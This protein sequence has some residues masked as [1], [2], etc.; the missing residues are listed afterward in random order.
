M[1]PNLLGQRKDGDCV[2]RHGFVAGDLW[3]YDE[4]LDVYEY[5]FVDFRFEPGPIYQVPLI[6]RFIPQNK[7]LDVVVSRIER[8]INTMV[9]GFWMKKQGEQ[10]KPTN[11][12]GGIV[13]EY[14][15]T[16][17]T[18]GNIS[19]VPGFV[20]SFMDLLTNYIEEQGVTTTTL[21]KIPKGVRSNAAIE[22]L[23]ESE[24]ASLAIPQRRYKQTVKHI[25]EKFLMIADDYFVKPQQ[26]R[27]L[28]KGEPNYFDVIGKKAK[29]AREKLGVPVEGE[30]ISLSSESHVDIEVEAGLGFT[31]TGKREAML[32]LVSEIFLPLAEKGFI[33]KQAVQTIVE[34]VAETYQFGATAELMSAFDSDQPQFTE[35]QQ[36]NLE[37]T[38]QVAVATVMKDLQG[39]GMFPDEQQRID[40]T[41][42]GEAEAIKDT[43]L[44]DNQSKSPLDEA[45]LEDKMQEMRRKEEKHQLSLQKMRQGI[46]IADDKADNEIKIK[47]AEA[48][49]EMVLKEEET[50]AKIKVQE[51]EAE[52][53]WKENI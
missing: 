18:Q 30:V 5:P 24:Y 48:I 41:K 51:K 33:P 15:S 29:E 50:D 37:Q 12:A 14:L 35:K 9:T 7:S 43:G 38:I 46:E 44:I 23:K 39:S 11:V 31:K 16:P 21:S 28:E 8:Y 6:E 52:V 19:P 40:E 27:F 2:I 32:R 13:Y 45:E 49:Q 10:F 26:V 42:M 47:K 3:L 20:F 22:S 53:T 25:A 4:Y 36:E 17:P 1:N 34:K